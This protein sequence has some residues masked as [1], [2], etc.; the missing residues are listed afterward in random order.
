MPCRTWMALLILLFVPARSPAQEVQFERPKLEAKEIEASFGVDWYGVYLDGTKVGFMRAGLNKGDNRYVESMAMTLKLVSNEQKVEV[1]F[2]QTLRFD[3]KAPYMLL[4]GELQIKAGGSTQKITLTK[5]EK[6]YK[7]SAQTGDATNVIP[8]GKIEYSLADSM[9]QETWLKKEPRQGAEIVTRELDM[10]KLEI[11]PQ[12]CTL[13]S[14]KD[15]LVGGVNVRYFE[16][17]TLNLKTKVDLL[18]RYDNQGKLLSGVMA[19][20]FEIRRETEEQAKD[21]KY[22][23][24]LFVLGMVKID[25]PLGPTEYVKELV[26]EVGEGAKQASALEDGPRQIVTKDKEG[27]VTIKIGKKYGKEAKANAKE[28]EDALAETAVYA[29]SNEKVK[30]LAKKAI[31]DADTPEEKVRRIVNFVNRFVRGKYIGT[32]PNI[33]DL[34]EKRE[35]DCKSYALLTTTLCRAAGVPSREVSG[36][37]YTGDHQKSFG[38][39]AWNEVVLNGIWVPVDSSLAETEVDAAHISF[40]TEAQAARAM[41][42]T[43]GKLSFKL[44]EVKRGK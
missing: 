14:T 38:G 8:V 43:L 2:A 44:V 22:S 1:N 15:S 3:N 13:L 4:D 11:Q 17:K 37:V 42:D 40:G 21:T 16:V 26:I 5:T 20:K 33:H 25:R 19:D 18:A 29:I 6:G 7:A 24:D 36:L 23:R 32:L 35:G 41:L 39:H 28:I 27:A 10:E 9:A 34:M 30:A 12:K 31:G